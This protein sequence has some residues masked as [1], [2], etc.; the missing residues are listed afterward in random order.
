MKFTLYQH[1]SQAL[2]PPKARVASGGF[3]P[4]E[5][6]FT[7]DE[8][9]QSQLLQLESEDMERPPKVFYTL[10]FPHLLTHEAVSTR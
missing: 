8:G 6:L 2:K 5:S 1:S 10:T 3:D 4:F 7:E 9:E